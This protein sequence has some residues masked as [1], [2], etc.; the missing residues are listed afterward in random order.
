MMWDAL[1]ENCCQ[2]KAEGPNLGG[3]TK[4]KQVVAESKTA[5]NGTGP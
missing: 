1:P 4:H 2:F 5:R 3:G